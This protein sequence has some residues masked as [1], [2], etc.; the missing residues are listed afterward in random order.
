MVKGELSE[1]IYRELHVGATW[2]LIYTHTQK[3]KGVVGLK[4]KN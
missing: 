4:T 2:R 3:Q 1:D